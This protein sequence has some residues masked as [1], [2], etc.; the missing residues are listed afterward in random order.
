MIGPGKFDDAIWHVKFHSFVQCCFS[1]WRI[2]NCI[3][4]VMK[5]Y[6]GKEIQR[7]QQVPL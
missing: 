2:I 1:R 5:Y 7:Q 3:P 6:I 4:V